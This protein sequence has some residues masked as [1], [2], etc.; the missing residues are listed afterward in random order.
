MLVRSQLF[1]KGL[2]EGPGGFAGTTAFRSPEILASLSR[3]TLYN[4]LTILISCGKGVGEPKLVPNPSIPRRTP[5]IA[6][7]ITFLQIQSPL[8]P[9]Y[10]SYQMS[11]RGS[12]KEGS[13]ALSQKIRVGHTAITSAGN[14]PHPPVFNILSFYGAHAPACR[15]SGVS[16][17]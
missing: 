10:K 15:G 9:P 12:I 6:H 17:M 8:P 5:Q 3:V 14:S 16:A 13:K 4:I 11:L 7:Q 1:L 2:A